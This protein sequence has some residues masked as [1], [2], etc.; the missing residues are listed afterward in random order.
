MMRWISTATDA[1]EGFLKL[2]FLN[3]FIKKRMAYQALSCGLILL[4]EVVYIFFHFCEKV[5][6]QIHFNFFTTKS[7]KKIKVKIN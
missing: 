1:N 2:I 7:W 4:Y 3:L 5:F 6:H